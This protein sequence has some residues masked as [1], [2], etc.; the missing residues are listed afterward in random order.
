MFGSFYFPWSK[1]KAFYHKGEQGAHVGGKDKGL[2]TR[3]LLRLDGEYPYQP[4]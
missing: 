1:H 3:S 2:T 4:I